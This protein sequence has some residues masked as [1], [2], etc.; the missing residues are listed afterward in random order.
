M[1]GCLWDGDTPF[2]SQGPNDGEAIL[3]R[4]NHH[5]NYREITTWSQKYTLLEI[6]ILVD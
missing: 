6:D 4:I 3:Q 5:N 1:C 2:E